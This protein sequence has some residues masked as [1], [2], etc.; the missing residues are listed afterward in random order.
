MANQIEATIYQIDGNP[1]AAPITVSFLT[2]ELV[3]Q[4]A[5]IST[6]PAVQSAIY[7]YNVV[8]NQQSVQTFYASETLATLVALANNGETT[9]TQATVLEVN[10]NR[11]APPGVQYSFPSAAILIGEITP[12][13][14]GVNAFI[15]YK[16]IKYYTAETQAT[17]YNNSNAG[18][19]G[20][21]IV[22][23]SGLNSSVRCGN[24]NSASGNYTTVFG[25]CNTSISSLSTISGGYGNTTAAQIS[26][27]GGGRFNTASGYLST[28]GGGCKNLTQAAHGFIG[29]GLC[30]NACNSTSQCLAIGAVVAGGVGN[31]TTGG[32]FNLSFCSF[33][34]PPT[35]CNA[36]QYSFVGGGFQNM[37]VGSQS[38]VVGG[39][40]NVACHA[41]FSGQFVGGGFCNYSTHN[42]TVVGGGVNNTANFWTTVV[43]GG[44]INTASGDT[45]SVG[46]GQ[47]NTASGGYSVVSGGKINLASAACSTISGGL[48]NSAVTGW[49]SIGGGRSNMVCGG[50]YPTIAGGYGNTASALYAS[51]LG[52]RLNV[53]SGVASAI[54]GGVSN[55]TSACA[56]AMIVG[57]NITA[58]RVCATFVNNLS[59]KNIPTASAGLPSGSVW[60]DA[61]DA[62]TLKIVP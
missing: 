16:G 52:G 18:G 15:Q 46:G 51:V 25:R 45:A 23:G 40:F 42:K 36:G 8:N 24:N 60:R 34:T 35:I 19:G 20:G 13:L 59:I 9:H 30:N 26:F 44:Y 32:V 29:G 47:C 43:A 56:C 1:Q 53:A 37:A 2:S 21:I 57:S 38:A 62:N 48:Q 3:I 55:T 49:G 39:C 31:N 17:L 61:A 27:V 33:T 12:P 6:I 11:Q 28:I 58:D 7:Y 41:T 50:L 4:E 10:G 5:L 54:V 22:V 14:S